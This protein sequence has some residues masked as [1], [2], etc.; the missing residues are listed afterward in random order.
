MSHKVSPIEPPAKLFKVDLGQPH[1]P[2]LTAPENRLLQIAVRRVH[3]FRLFQVLEDFE[4]TLSTTA[5][6]RNDLVA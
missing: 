1:I 5:Q 3:L 4:E 6:D 2:Q